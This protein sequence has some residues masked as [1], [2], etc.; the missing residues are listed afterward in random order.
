MFVHALVSLPTTPV[1]HSYERNAKA[2]RLTLLVKMSKQQGKMVS[3][4][5]A[6]WLVEM[7]SLTRVLGNKDA[8]SI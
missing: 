3:L 7:P 1:P 8:D 5:L 2:I 6:L 4:L